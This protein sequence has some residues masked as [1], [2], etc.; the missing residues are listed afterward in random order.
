MFSD[1]ATR[2]VR[3]SGRPCDEC[4]R[5]DRYLERTLEHDSGRLWG[6]VCSRRCER[7]VLAR[8]AG[9]TLIRADQEYLAD[10]RR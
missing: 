6:H 10:A 5:A 9:A 2:E 3:Y 4:G 7:A 1:P 8:E